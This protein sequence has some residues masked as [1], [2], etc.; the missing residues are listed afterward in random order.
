[1]SVDLATISSRI[2]SLEAGHRVFLPTPYEEVSDMISMAPGS[3]EATFLSEYWVYP[4]P[5]HKKSQR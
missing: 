1:M 5:N 2:S 4:E 3:Q